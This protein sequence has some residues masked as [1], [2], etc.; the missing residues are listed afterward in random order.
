MAAKNDSRWLERFEIYKDYVNNFHKFPTQTNIIHKGDKIGSWFHSQIVSYNKGTLGEFRIRLMDEFNPSWKDITA[1]KNSAK[2]SLISSDWKSKVPKG[3][4]PIDVM[5]E[6]KDI[7]YLCI[8]NGIYDCESYMSSSYKERFD[9]YKYVSILTGFDPYYIR[10]LA[11][12][13]CY[14][15]HV[16]GL[17]ELLN[18]FPFSSK[19]D[20]ISRIDDL[21]DT[22]QVIEKRILELRFGLKTSPHTLKE[23]GNIYGVTDS[24]V[25][26]IEARAIRKIRHPGRLTQ[27]YITNTKLDDLIRD[28]ALR[29]KLFMN[30]VKSKEDIIPFIETE[31]FNKLST[32]E[33]N[34][35]IKIIPSIV[36]ID[37]T[38]TQVSI[39]ELHLSVRAFNCLKRAGKHTVGDLLVMTEDDLMKIRN[40]GNVQRLEVM[41]KLIPYRHLLVNS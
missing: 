33:Q 18:K 2:S 30:N 36:H 22:L 20:M 21:L 27:L 26:Q 29:V 16:E 8:K 7:L 15:D 19:E 3:N 40:L 35:I 24:R 13:F 39:S 28:R 34:I 41:Q 14:D 4:I 11:T 9:I 10:F 25:R 32:E 1:R 38:N 12:I 31:K 6:D 23:V 5:V 37:Y 17:K